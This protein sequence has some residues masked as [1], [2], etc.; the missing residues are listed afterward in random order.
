MNQKDRIRWKRLKQ[1]ESSLML[2]YQGF[3]GN[4][5][6][7]QGVRKNGLIIFTNQLLYR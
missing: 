3:A 1:I 4:Q 6:K 2:D 5:T 7:H